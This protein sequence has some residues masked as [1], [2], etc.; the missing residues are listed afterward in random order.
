MK[1][2]LALV[3]ALGII[4]LSGCNLEND[5]NSRAHTSAQTT[6]T[7]EEPTTEPTPLQTTTAD[8]SAST[9]LLPTDVIPEAVQTPRVDGNR[10]SYTIKNVYSGDDY[11]TVD[12]SGVKYEDSDGTDIDTTYVKGELY[13]DF[14]L[15]LLKKGEIIDSLKINVPRDDR[16][17]I[18]ESVTDNLSYGCELISNMREYGAAEYPDLIQ[19]DFHMINEGEVP[20]YARYFAV[21]DG[22]IC[23]VPV[24][25]NGKE[26]APYG[27]HPKMRS[28][29]LMTQFITAGTYTGQYTVLKYEYTFDVENRCLRK[30]Q[31]KFYGWED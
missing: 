1:K 13:G 3:A 21:F 9:S 11:Y 28:A 29:G 18:L 10:L 25:M 5:E 4:C 15:D 19:L 26:S 14:R 30:Q 6:M 17:L 23:E 22:K 2:A 16:F 27:T 8:T 31:V 7:E 24:L 12:I 20:Q